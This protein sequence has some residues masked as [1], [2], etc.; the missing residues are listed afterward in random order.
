MGRE[1]IFFLGFVGEIE[2]FGGFWFWGL[3]FSGHY[4]FMVGF[5]WLG[6]QWLG[7]RW[8]QWSHDLRLSLGMSLAEYDHWIGFVLFFFFCRKLSLDWFGFFYLLVFF[9]FFCLVCF[10]A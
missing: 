2:L 10:L 8:R 7:F 9:F 6:I 5:Q 4:G 1:C 3:V